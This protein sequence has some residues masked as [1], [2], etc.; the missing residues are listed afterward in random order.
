MK[1]VKCEQGCLLCNDSL[2][3]LRLLSAEQDSTVTAVTNGLYTSLAL[4]S[5]AQFS[6]HATHLT[7]ME[8]IP[9]VE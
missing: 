7:I 6:G 4:K 3:S 9:S 8:G 5:V 2:S 1:S